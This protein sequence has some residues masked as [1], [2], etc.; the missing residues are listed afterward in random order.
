MTSGVSIRDASERGAEVCV[1]IYASYVTGTVISFE[2]ELPLLRRWPR[3]LPPP[4]PS[5]PGSYSKDAQRVVGFAYGIPFAERPAYRWACQTSIY[6]EMDRRRTGGGRSLYTALLD[7]LDSAVV[8]RLGQNSQG[9]H[10][11]VFAGVVFSCQH[12]EIRAK[13]DGHVTT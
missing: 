1:V 3:A 2:L 7:R 12:S 5:T 11:G 13:G 8:Q 4:L 6:L 9:V 10:H